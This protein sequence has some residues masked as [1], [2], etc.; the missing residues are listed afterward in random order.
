MDLNQTKRRASRFVVGWLLICAVVCQ[1]QTP[2]TPNQEVTVL[3]TATDKDQ[4]LI[5]IRA[6][7]LKVTEDSDPRPITRFQ[8]IKDSPTTITIIIDISISQERTL[9]AQKM[10]PPLSLIRLFGL[11]A[12]KQPSQR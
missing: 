3:V 9:D 1:G 4:N 8:P 7:D 11:T 5:A 12:I 10:R 2:A 6:E